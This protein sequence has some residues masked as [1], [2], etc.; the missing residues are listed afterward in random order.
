MNKQESKIDMLKMYEALM[1]E[2]KTK[3]E[4][5]KKTAISKTHLPALN[6]YFDAIKMYGAS[7]NDAV[8]IEQKKSLKL[9]QTISTKVR[10]E[11]EN[12]EH[13]DRLKNKIKEQNLMID[14]YKISISNIHKSVQKSAEIE[15]SKAFKKIDYS[16]IEKGYARGFKYLVVVV[17]VM[18]IMLVAQQVQINNTTK[19]LYYTPSEI[20]YM[21]KNQI[22]EN[23]KYPKDDRWII[24]DAAYEFSI[25]DDNSGCAIRLKK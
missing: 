4:I 8:R 13:I 21:I 19:V 3:D 2:G 23:M 12:L 11:R 15:L 14:N 6:R 18:V 17:V 16:P 10:I 20:E 22:P 24:S 7:E 9:K 5:E 25:F 1:K